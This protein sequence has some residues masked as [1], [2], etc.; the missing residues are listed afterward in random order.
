MRKAGAADARLRGHDEAGKP[1]RYRFGTN[2]APCSWVS[3]PSL[4][5]QAM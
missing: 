4:S 2:S 5:V 3:A 1:A